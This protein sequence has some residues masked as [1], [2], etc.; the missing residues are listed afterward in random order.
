MAREPWETKYYDE[1]PIG[2]K[3]A[4][5]QRA[6]KA[7]ANYIKTL[8]EYQI[9][10]AKYNQWKK[11]NPYIFGTAD[12]M[13]EPIGIYQ[14]HYPRFLKQE[15]LKDYPELGEDISVG[16]EGAKAQR[17]L[18]LCRKPE[19][20]G[21][22]RAEFVR[23]SEEVK[24]SEYFE[25]LREELKPSVLRVAKSTKKQKSHKRSGSSV[26]VKGLRR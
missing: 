17:L 11:E 4:I 5:A 22:E 8:P 20:T 2:E 23:L 19:L 12:M 3:Q 25:L 15:V 18:E 14:E 9:A 21:I 26:G 13:A 6:D 10:I 1:L 7:T 24:P 16:L